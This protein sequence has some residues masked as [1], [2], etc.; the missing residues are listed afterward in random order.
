MLTQQKQV[1]TEEYH[2]TITT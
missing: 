1:P 2:N